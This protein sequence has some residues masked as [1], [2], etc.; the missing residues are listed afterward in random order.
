MSQ[1]SASQDGWL[2]VGLIVVL[3]SAFIAI[4]G[5]SLALAESR[6]VLSLRENEIEAISLAQAGVMQA[7]YDVRRMTSVDGGVVLREYNVD[8]PS[9]PPPGSNDDAFILGGQAA[10]FLVANMKGLLFRDTNACGNSGSR[11]EWRMMNV[12]AS[13]TPPTGLPL[14]VDRVVVTWSPDQGERVVL[15][16][17]GARRS[18]ENCAGVSNGEEIDL[19]NV[20]FP[21]RTI[22]RPGANVMI[23]NSRMQNT[24]WIDIA[25]RMTDGSVR[26]SH[27]ESNVANRSADV[28]IKSVGE[29]RRGSFPFVSWRRLQAEYRL[30]S[31][32]YTS[33]G[34]LLSYRE[35]TQKIP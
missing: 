25:F 9:G 31:N 7:L 13:D 27:Y 32:T 14:V 22:T 20:T 18:W 16:Y 26:A 19:T 2:L 21:P 23:F 15:F 34:N 35:L 3:S 6:R 24:S 11:V 8:N 33:V 29:V 30:S 5:V 1:S 12:L 28:T 17:I 4:G 10:D